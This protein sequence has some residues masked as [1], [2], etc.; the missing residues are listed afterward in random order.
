MK[1][2]LR[3][4]MI[5]KPQARDDKFFHRSPDLHLQFPFQEVLLRTYLRIFLS[6]GMPIDYLAL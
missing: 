6:L 5:C 1:E 3:W 4:S 2:M